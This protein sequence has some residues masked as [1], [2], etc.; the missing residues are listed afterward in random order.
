MKLDVCPNNGSWVGQPSL[1]VIH[2]NTQ[3][4]FTNI[5]QQNDSTASV[6]SN[7]F[8]QGQNSG[9]I[10]GVQWLHAPKSTSSPLQ[11]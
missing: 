5:C 4:K 11:C 8:L 1:L 2:K 10:Y 6:N 7:A 9:V 3:T